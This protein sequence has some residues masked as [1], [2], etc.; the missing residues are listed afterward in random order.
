[1][2][3]LMNVHI[4]KCNRRKPSA[5]AVAALVGGDESSV[6]DQIL[7]SSSRRSSRIKQHV[8]CTTELVDSDDSSVEVHSDNE[9]RPPNKLFKMET[10]QNNSR[11]RTNCSNSSFNNESVLRSDHDLSED[12]E[13]FLTAGEQ[14]KAFVQDDWED[15]DFETRSTLLPNEVL[16]YSETSFGSQVPTLSWEKLF[17]YQAE[18]CHW[19]YDLYQEGI[20]GILGDEMGESTFF[21]ILVC[22]LLNVL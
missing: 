8:P 5:I 19:L 3:H 17:T 9:Y 18:G 15:D 11:K 21:S 12:E 22:S 20:G 2:N 4:E 14:V 7:T 13:E 10:K 16:E 6:D 1:M